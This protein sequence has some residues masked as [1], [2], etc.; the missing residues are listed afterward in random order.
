M[1]NLSL[2]VTALWIAGSLFTSCKYS[3]STPGETHTTDSGFVF[4]KQFT[5]N[6]DFYIV[7]TADNSGNNG[8]KIIST[9]RVSH[10]EIVV[11][12][13]LTYIGKSHVA[14]VVTFDATLTPPNDTNYFCLETNG[15]L[16]RYNFGFN[17]LNQFPFLVAAI[18]QKIDEGW[19]LV[20]KMNAASGTTFT[21][22]SEDSIAISFL[23]VKV[24]LSSTGTMLNDTT[25]YIGSDTLL[26]RHARHHVITTVPKTDIGEEHADGYVDTY[27]SPKLGAFPIDF[28]HA[29]KLDGTI[30]KSQAQGKFKIM[31]THN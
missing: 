23:N 16:Y 8:D 5:A 28:Y 14:R 11:D 22:K 7:D 27:I 26:C 30:T 3:P 15:D 12:T 4:K 17:I 20:A 1:K 21:A 25:I 31:T 29:T 13:G 24:H 6:Y 2:L 19:V 9:S 18:G 10:A